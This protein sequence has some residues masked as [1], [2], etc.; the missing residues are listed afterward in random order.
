MAFST[1]PKPTIYRHLYENTDPGSSFFIERSNAGLTLNQQRV[2]R[3]F[4]IKESY[5]L[6]CKVADTT[7]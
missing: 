5:L 3:H 6:L 2:N 7:S 1:N 4:G